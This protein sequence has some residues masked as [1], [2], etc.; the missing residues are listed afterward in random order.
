MS[1]I[2]GNEALETGGGRKMRKARRCKGRLDDGT[3]CGATLSYM[4]QN[5]R[6]VRLMEECPYC[7]R[8]VNKNERPEEKKERERY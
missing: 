4:R 2:E 6:K 8:P 5:S 1:V 7:G 3:E